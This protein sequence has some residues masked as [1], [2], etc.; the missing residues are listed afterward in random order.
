MRI[1]T[2]QVEEYRGCKVYFRNFLTHFEYLIVIK[3]ELYTAHL[4]AQQPLA[5]HIRSLFGVKDMFIP[6]HEAVII[7]RLRVTARTTIDFVLDK[8]NK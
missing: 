3:G 6:R 1:K 4:T 5:D 8:K 2:Y 7:E